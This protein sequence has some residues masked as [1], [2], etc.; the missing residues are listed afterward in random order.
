MLEYCPAGESIT[1][2]FTY[3]FL[4]RLPREIRVLLSEEELADVRAIADKAD[5][6]IAMHVPQHHDACAAVASGE[7]S[8]PGDIV[9]ATQDVRRKKFKLPTAQRPQQQQQGG[10]ARWHEASRCPQGVQGGLRMSMCFYH[11]K[12]DEQ[13]RYYEEGCLWPEN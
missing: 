2:V 5:C 10:Q 8:D 11:A 13:A 1:A 12:Y 6:L 9:A 7:D 4:Q 3:L